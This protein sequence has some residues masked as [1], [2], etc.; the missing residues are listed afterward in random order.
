MKIALASDVH[1]E[2]GDL[3]LTNDQQADVLILAGDILVAQDLR[4]FVHDTEE[5]QSVVRGL[6][7][8]VRA[9]R[10]WDFITRCTQQFGR[11][12]YVAGN[13]EHYHGNFATTLDVLRESLASFQNL[14]MLDCESLM[15]DDVL[16]YGG[17]LWTDFNNR[18]PATLRDIKFLMNDFQVVKNTQYNAD[19]YLNRFLPEDALADHER[20]L[21]GLHKTLQDHPV[22]KTVVVGHHAPS[23]ASTHPRYQH[24]TLMNGAYSTNLEHIM[25][26]NVQIK[27]WCHGHTHSN[28]DYMIG[29]TR[30][31]CN[32]RGYDGYEDQADRF[33]LKY[34][35]I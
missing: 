22:Q 17:T 10:Y 13:H 14:H 24:E 28:F 26:D 11:V 15:L 29:S 31:M 33:T 35:E 20:F 32:P 8:Q 34:V 12:I 6:S 3:V 23:K 16:F 25:L 9:Q 1:L 21:Q 30:V 18:D 2:M 27:L 4:Q 19:Q 7:G 5:A